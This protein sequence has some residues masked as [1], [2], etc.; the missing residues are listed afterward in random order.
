M[1][2]VGIDIT[3]TIYQRGVSRYTSNLV[4]ALLQQ[5]DLKLTL[6]GSSLRQRQ[7]LLDQAAAF[8]KETDSKAETVIQH[9]PPSLYNFLWNKI[10]YPKLRSVMPKIQLFHSW[11]WLQP[12]DKDLPLISTI[13]DV[14]VLK[15]PETAHPKILSMHQQS[16]DVLKK[17]KAVIIAVSRATKKDVVQ[18]LG[19]P[20]S[21]V[22]VV[23][24]ALPIEVSR[25][26]EEMTDDRQQAITEKLQ[27]KRPFILFVGT[28]EPRKNIKNL[29][30]AW[31]PLH[32]DVDLVV[33]GEEGWDETNAAD[34][35][36]V[37]PHLRFLGKVSDEELAVLYTEAQV[38][39][40]PSLYEGF[41]LPILEAFYHG[42]PVV[43][44]NVSS[45][46]EVAG[47]AAELVDPLSVESIRDGITTI[48]QEDHTE[49]Q[50]RMQRMII[51]QQM[52]SWQTVAQETI[53]VYKQALKLSE[54]AS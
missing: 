3:A 35:K 9:Y 25:V 10:G 22:F 38:F 47:N 52:F 16:W 8:K 36:D 44:S 34:Y 40:F 21:H 18:L 43:T 4:R 32:K 1:L 53:R 12:P 24:E 45:M 7:Q 30:E 26:S 54:L 29:I 48:L 14:A 19:F 28:R 27:L 17:R 5:K 33:A 46:P 50:L 20:E 51:R 6:Y 42:T 2:H 11:D 13:H 15:Y 49:Q 31:R 23:H 41:G 37:E 39:A